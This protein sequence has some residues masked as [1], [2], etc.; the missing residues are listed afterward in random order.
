MIIENNLGKK[1]ILPDSLELY[2]PFPNYIDSKEII[3]FKFRIYSHI[4]ASCGTCIE[5][6]KAWNNLIP[7]LKGKGIQVILIC[8][9]DNRFE[10][11]KYYFESKEI[12][13]FNH[14][15]WLDL[16]NN[17]IKNN[18]FMLESK[19]FETVLT[20]NNDK[21][22]L[23]GNPNFSNKIKELYFKEIKKDQN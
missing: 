23:V 21:I 7:E 17:F 20:D 19:N 10:L 3:N 4:D 9:S 1:L 14:P 12:E 16:K 5:T 6:L 15:L 13:N 8:S 18:K 2:H 22:L 11:L